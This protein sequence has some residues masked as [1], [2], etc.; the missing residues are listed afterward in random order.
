[1]FFCK[2][3]FVEVPKPLSVKGLDGLLDKSNF[4]E[5][6]SLSLILQFA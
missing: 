3:I 4:L 6:R 5:I 1:V 2:D